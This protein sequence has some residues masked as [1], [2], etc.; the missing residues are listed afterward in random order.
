MEAVLDLHQNLL[1]KPSLRELVRR[2]LRWG[3]VQPM[4]VLAD[5]PPPPAFAQL[6]AH[7]RQ[8]H[9]PSLR[10]MY[11][12][13]WGDAQR[14]F[15]FLNPAGDWLACVTLT[16]CAPLGWHTE[17]LLRRT[18]API[19]V[20]EATLAAAHQALQAEGAR[21]LSLGEVPFV[22][23]GGGF[24]A[25][26]ARWV[27]NR[28]RFAYNAQGLYAFKHKFRP[29]WQPL[30]LCSTQSIGLLALTDMY[31][32]AGV[33][34]LTLAAAWQYLQGTHKRGY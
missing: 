25:Q 27:G 30:Y 11:R 8:G 24:W 34:C 4:A 22:G 32:R 12:T 21:F 13:D 23:T 10:G 6:W 26:A 2:G 29:H 5:T 7:S 16:P 28:L 1:A 19:G 20:L 14:A 9:L 18:D 17:L 3:Q 31:F 15:V 33:A